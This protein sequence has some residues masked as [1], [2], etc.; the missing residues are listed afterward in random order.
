MKHTDYFFD[1]IFLLGKH[2]RIYTHV[3]VCRGQKP[4]L[5]QFKSIQMTCL[6]LR[7]CYMQATF[8]Q[9]VYKKNREAQQKKRNDSKIQTVRYSMCYVLLQVRKTDHHVIL[10]RS[11]RQDTTSLEKGTVPFMQQELKALTQCHYWRRPCGGLLAGIFRGIV[12]LSD[13]LQNTSVICLHFTAATHDDRCRFI[14]P[15]IRV[16]VSAMQ[17]HAWSHLPEYTDTYIY[18][19]FHSLICSC[20][21]LFVVAPPRLIV[22]GALFWP[23]VP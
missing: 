2:Y 18:W 23:G 3:M 7:F 9:D 12:N 6:T 20:L 22:T 8:H 15:S 4:D 21:L 5:F 14:C 10:E 16:K 1:L 19:S 11:K 17:P 13:D